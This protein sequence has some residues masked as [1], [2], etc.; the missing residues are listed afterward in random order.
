MDELMEPPRILPGDA[1]VLVFEDLVRGAS[2]APLDAAVFALWCDSAVDL[3]ASVPHE[4]QR[5][6]WAYHLV[7]PLSGGAQWQTVVLGDLMRCAEEV[8]RCR[9]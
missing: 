9:V 2:T 7:Q 6:S 4:D 3:L 5:L 8:R 1:L